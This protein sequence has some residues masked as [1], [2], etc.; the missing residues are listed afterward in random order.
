MEIEDG[1]EVIL[2][3]CVFSNAAEMETF[4]IQEF[5]DIENLKKYKYAYVLKCKF[6]AKQGKW[7]GRRDSNAAASPF[8]LAFKTRKF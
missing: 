3:A 5:G 8:C 2:Y 4:D 1:K 6:S 7:R